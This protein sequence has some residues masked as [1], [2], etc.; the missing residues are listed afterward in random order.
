M[1]RVR[2]M[3]P[4]LL[5][6]LL[7]L[8]GC[9][10]SVREKDVPASTYDLNDYTAY[11]WEGGRTVNEAVLPMREENGDIE[12]IALMYPINS[13]V[14]VW[15][16]ELTIPYLPGRD[17]TVENGCLVIPAGSTIPVLDH[18]RLYLSELLDAN[19]FE[20]TKS[21]YIFFSE[22]DFFH[23]AQLAVTYTHTAAWQG[24]IPPAQGGLLPHTLS[25]LANGQTLNV[26]YYG[27]SVTAGCNSSSVIQ[28]APYAPRWTDM[29]TQR[30]QALYPDASVNAW[31]EAV[32]G[33][34]S[35]WGEKNAALVASHQPD[36]VI[37]AF[38]LNDASRQ[39]RAEAYQQSIQSILDTVL[40]AAPDCE[41]ILVSSMRSN[42]EAWEFQGEK[43]PAYRKALLALTGQGV[44][45]AD[46]TTLHE[47]LLA[48]KQYR[49]M[50][51]N[52]INHCNDFLARA[53]AQLVLRT[54]EE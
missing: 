8:P 42:A 13:I 23:K 46:M 11:Y 20:A 37:I 33:A 10:S 51:G 34:D 15:N 24:Q 2:K 7:F 32:G 52:N 12:P 4:L 38:G 35:A 18:D 27:D 48:R 28:A 16:A 54:L 41:F 43:L 19:G 17:Y 14:S 5:S 47:D 39:G 44:V 29:V 9:T 22:G 1:I 6:C 3:L 45:M 31:N 25:K 26:V 40:T 49:D 21:G 30:I 50:T 53:Y 36:L